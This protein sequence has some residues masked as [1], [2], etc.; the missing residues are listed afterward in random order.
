[1]LEVHNASANFGNRSFRYDKGVA[2]AAVESNREIAR[3]LEVL[4][5]IVTH[6]HAIGVVEKDVGRHEGGVGEQASRN[7]LRLIAL[8]FELCHAAELADRCSALH[9]PRKLS[10]FPNVALNKECGSG[11]VDADSQEKLGQFEG[12]GSKLSGVLGD[13]KSVEINDAEDGV[14]LGLVGDP[15]AQ[16]S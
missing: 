12:P 4:T 16:G 6:R 8:I 2:V 3:Q 7:E 11:R 9:K 5:L 13:G 1:M 14:R 15:V 10:V